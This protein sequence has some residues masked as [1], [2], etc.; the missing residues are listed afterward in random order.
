[1]VSPDYLGTAGIAPGVRST[2]CAGGSKASNSRWFGVK[3]RC[4]SGRRNPDRQDATPA[5][6]LE[7]RNP[8]IEIRPRRGG[9]VNK[10]Q[11]PKPKIR[12]GAEAGAG[13][14]V[15]RALGF[16]FVSDLRSRI[17]GVGF[18]ASDLPS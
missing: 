14:W 6:H 2:L 5:L 18:R 1:M 11:G 8:N 12:N 3:R 4:A 9:N 13:V 17:R 7:I 10:H 16:E 15:I